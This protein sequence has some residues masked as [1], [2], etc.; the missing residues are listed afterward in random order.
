MLDLLARFAENSFWMARY[1]ERAENLARILDVNETFARDSKGEQ[2]WLPIV[3]IFAD[4]DEFFESHDKATAD[5]VVDFYVTDRNNL[6]SI[7]SCVWSARENA[8]SLRHLISVEVWR[9]LN[10]FHNDL[11]G[12]RKKDLKP[13][14]LPDLCQSIKDSC[15]QHAGIMDGTA[16]RDQAWHFY[17]IGKM[18]E[19]ADQMTRLVD[20]KYHTL[21]PKVEDVGTPVDVAQWNAVLRSAA[22]YHSFRR[23]YPRG[24]KPE[25]VVTFMLFDPAFPR[26]LNSCIRQLQELLYNLQAIH[27]ERVKPAVAMVEGLESLVRFRRSEEILTDGLHEYLDRVQLR[28]LDLSAHLGLIFFGYEKPE[29]EGG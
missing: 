16:Y 3:H 23:V 1:M 7:S 19:R 4:N 15:Q 20:I 27:G 24:M 8:R 17:R 13:S 2:N 9:Q 22:G 28:L 25:N 10:V 26:S 21:L 5:A 29:D 6:N 18:L 11:K 14:V 12:V